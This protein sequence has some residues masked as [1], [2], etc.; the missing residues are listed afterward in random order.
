[1]L[2]LGIFE[3]KYL[4]SLSNIPADWYIAGKVLS[5]E[6]IPDETINKF[7]VKSRLPLSTWRQNNWT[8]TDKFGW[9]EWYCQYY[10]GRRLDEDE[11]QIGR[12]K[13]FVTLHQSQ[14]TLNCKDDLECRPKQKQALL[15][16]AWD[17]NT[18][19]T[20][21][22]L[23]LN[24]KEIS[25][26]ANTEISVV[27]L[28]SFNLA[29]EIIIENNYKPV[30]SNDFKGW[31]LIPGVTGYL[32]NKQGLMLRVTDKNSSKGHFDGRYYKV[33]WQN[34]PI[35]LPPKEYV[36]R[37]IAL[38]FY[39]PVDESYGRIIVDHVNGDKKDNDYKNLRYATVSEN[40]IYSYKLGTKVPTR[41]K[42]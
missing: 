41:K 26:K 3:G 17:S 28:E 4:N 23:E 7:K 6:E 9:F 38:A 40:L 29:V 37:L 8:K 34:D 27:S 32:A 16:W 10:Q 39:G 42:W 31:Y 25:K 2:E 14:I 33:P 35:N 21:K 15:Q 30:E 1:M 19:F 13:S 36:H 18:E 22:Q 24:L 12:W 20:E 5:K 11:W